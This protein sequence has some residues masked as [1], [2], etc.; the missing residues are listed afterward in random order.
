MEPL[1][2]KGQQ[3]RPAL[4]QAAR[5]RAPLS[6]C[7]LSPACCSLLP[8]AASH[9]DPRDRRLG[10]MSAREQCS[11]SFLSSRTSELSPRAQ[12][13]VSLSRPRAETAGTVPL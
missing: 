2:G 1:P 6:G 11:P 8:A 10:R 9:L 12:T 3:G 5:R 4:Q 7:V 13:P